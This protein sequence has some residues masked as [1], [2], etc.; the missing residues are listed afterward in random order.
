[1]MTSQKALYLGQEY[2]NL[3]PGISGSWQVSDRN[4]SSFAERAVFDT[5]YETNL[6]FREDLRI[7][8]ATVGV[9]FKANGY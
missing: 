1:M 4:T 3:V 9:V 2:Y 7:L 5:T 6:S 8:T